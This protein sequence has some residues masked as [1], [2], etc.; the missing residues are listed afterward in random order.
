[1]WPEHRTGLPLG[2]LVGTVCLWGVSPFSDG[3]LDRT[4]LIWKK[5]NCAPPGGL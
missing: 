2:Y 5:P 4:D 1:M 3:I